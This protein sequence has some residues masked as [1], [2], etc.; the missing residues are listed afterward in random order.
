[1]LGSLAVKMGEKFAADRA[2]EVENWKWLSVQTD[3]EETR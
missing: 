1:M 3:M 2:R